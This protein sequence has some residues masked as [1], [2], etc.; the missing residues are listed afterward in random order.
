MRTREIPRS[1]WAGYLTTLS[2]RCADHP[3]RV[4]VESQEIGDQ[5]MV[6]CLPFVGI[7]LEE[8]GSE[9]GSIELTVSKGGTDHLT[10]LIEGPEHVFVEEDDAGQV[11][12]L[13]IEDGSK[14]KTIVFFEDWEALP[15]KG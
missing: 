2:R 9:A 14:V 7:S 12:V 6:E 15:E 13:D 1:D 8:K 4:R 10:H 5:A 3:V 11:A